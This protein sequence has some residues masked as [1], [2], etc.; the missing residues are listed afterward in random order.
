MTQEISRSPKEHT[1]KCFILYMITSDPDCLLK[2]HSWVWRIAPGNLVVSTTTWLN[3]HT[4]K[5]Y[6]LSR[7]SVTC[8]ITIGLHCFTWNRQL[9]SWIF[10]TKSIW[11]GQSLRLPLTIFDAISYSLIMWTI[12]SSVTE[13]WIYDLS[14]ETLLTCLL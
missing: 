10:Q 7:L 4:A 3:E 12:Q 6:I 11:T 2:L 9:W 1:V 5:I 8:L 13:I 14:Y